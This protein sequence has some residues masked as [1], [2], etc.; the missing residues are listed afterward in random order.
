[1]VAVE[2][3]ARPFEPASTV[4]TWRVG[5]NALDCRIFSLKAPQAW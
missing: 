5:S 2:V 3:G 4:A 1:V